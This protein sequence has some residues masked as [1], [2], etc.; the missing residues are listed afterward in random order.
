MKPFAC[1]L[2]ASFLL[3]AQA[4]E[5]NPAPNGLLMIKRVYVAN[6]TGGAQADA[7]RELVIASLDSTKLFILTD[8]PDRADAVLKGAAD[9][10]SVT[11]TYDSDEN[12]NSRQNGGKSGSL[13]SKAGGIYGGLGVG[14]NE[15]HHIKEH[16]HE[17]YATV[18][19]CTKDGDVLWSTTQQSDGAKFR[20]AS[21]DV[22]FK[23]ARQLS[24]DVERA[25][26]ELPQTAKPP[27]PPVR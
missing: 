12:F 22:A 1:L 11:D 14:A 3:H 7:I 8:N 24:F 23:I 15:S 10:Q 9:D 6:L 20:S 4:P 16:K 5:K 18:R 21:A 26:K 19:L 27:A 17:A 2:A 25:Q 13:Y